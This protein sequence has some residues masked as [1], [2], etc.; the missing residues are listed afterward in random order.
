MYTKIYYG[1]RIGTLRSV[2]HTLRTTLT[3]KPPYMPV[4]IIDYIGWVNTILP[5]NLFLEIEF[6]SRDDPPDQMKVILNGID[7]EE[8][9]SQQISQFDL[10]TYLKTLKMFTTQQMMPELLRVSY[11]NE[12]NK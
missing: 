3:T 5:E 4:D 6:A 12:L 1:N 9:I 10:N 7:D 8:D 11:K 2:F